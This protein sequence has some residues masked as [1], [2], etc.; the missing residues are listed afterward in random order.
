M[1][2]YFPEKAKASSVTIV[3][4]SRNGTFVRFFLLF[5]SRVLTIFTRYEDIGSQH[6]I[7]M[8][9]TQATTLLLGRQRKS[10][11]RAY[12]VSVSNG[13]Y[14]RVHI[15]FHWRRIHIS[16]HSQGV[17]SHEGHSKG[18]MFL[19]RG[20]RTAVEAKYDMAMEYASSSSWNARY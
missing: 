3:D 17:W 9:S 20:A 8:S 18:L 19:Q 1:I 7:P 10:K 2:K 15:S 4:Q 14:C 16:A 13:D 5:S 11:T 6:S 12:L